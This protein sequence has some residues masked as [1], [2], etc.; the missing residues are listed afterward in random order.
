M[1]ATLGAPERRLGG[2]RGTVVRDAE[3]EPVPTSRVTVITP[4]PFP[5]PAEAA[6]WLGRVRAGGGAHT[7][8]DDAVAVV[9]RA[10][11]AHRVAQADPC[12]R[13]ITVDQALVVRLGFGGG[14]ALAEGRFE[15]AWEPPRDRRRPAR[16]SMEA[17]DER[18]AALLGA[19]ETALACEELLLRARADLAAGRAREAALEA[20]VA[21]ESLLSELGE[22]LEGDRRAALE[23]DRAPVAEA[24]N[25]ALRGP[26]SRQLHG[27][28][29]G[30]VSR[31]EAALRARRLT[32]SA[33]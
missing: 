28:V 10:V 27:A 30:A 6:E 23:A 9:N 3:P 22:V 21:L 25:A 1:L 32:S 18:F 4:E 26:P 17:P 20:R 5:G 2:R 12:A 11:H 24:A 8:V 33:S 14:D 19:R 31:M 29:K 7:E 13:D 16:R 15:E